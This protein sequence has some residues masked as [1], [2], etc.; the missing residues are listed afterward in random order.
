[1]LRIKTS[2]SRL[3]G[4]SDSR[5]LCQTFFMVL[6]FRSESACEP[7]NAAARRATRRRRDSGF[8]FQNSLMDI[9]SYPHF[10]LSPVCHAD[11]ACC[12]SRSL[13]GLRSGGIT[14]SSPATSSSETVSFKLKSTVALYLYGL[15]S[16]SPTE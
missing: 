9:S 15:A 10:Y 14:I 2:L 6:L 1:M 3:V 4:K 8:R 7:M 16:C 11:K 12:T 5:D 13:T